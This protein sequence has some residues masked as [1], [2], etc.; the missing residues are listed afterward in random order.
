[1]AVTVREV[2]RLMARRT[3]ARPRCCSTVPSGATTFSIRYGLSS[4]PPLAMAAIAT[5]SCR[6]VADMPCPNAVVSRAICAILR[7]SPSTPRA[8][9]GSPTPVFSPKPKARSPSTIFSLP[10]RSPIF[11]AQMFDD[12]RSTVAGVAQSM[13]WVS[14]SLLPAWAQRPCSQ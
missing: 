7:G 1:M 11:A 8:S 4:M 9:P 5:V 10:S 13:G 14:W 12:S 2:A 3:S 6:P